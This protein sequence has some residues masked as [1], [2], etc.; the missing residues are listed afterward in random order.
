MVVTAGAKAIEL[1][2]DVWAGLPSTTF[3][4]QLCSTCYTAVQ[5][6]KCSKS[7]SVLKVATMKISC[8]AKE[9]ITCNHHINAFHCQQR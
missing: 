8:Y 4:C 1:E 6:K 7:T 9:A 2:G 5:I 3:S